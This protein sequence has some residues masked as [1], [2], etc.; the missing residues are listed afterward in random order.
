MLHLPYELMVA[1]LPG[2]AR[3]LLAYVGLDWDDAWRIIAEHG[4]VVREPSQG[5]VDELPVV[6]GLLVTWGL[7]G[8]LTRGRWELP[9]GVPARRPI[10]TSGDPTPPATRNPVAP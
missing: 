6:L 10:Q 5:A 9:A 8:L 1:D 2:Q 7:I 3:R 4:A